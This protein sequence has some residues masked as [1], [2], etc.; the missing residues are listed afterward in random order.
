MKF[1]KAEKQA[2][3]FAVIYIRKI[4]FIDEQKVSIDEEYDR[5]DFDAD[6]FLIE[7]NNNYI[8]TCRIYYKD[9]EATIG[10]V[11]VIKE[12]RNKGYAKF[13]MEKAID[14]I[15]MKKVHTIHIGAQV[16]A[17]GFYEKLGFT[18][19]GDLYLDANIEHY[20]MEMIL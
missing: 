7:E 5:L 13:M 18:V 9:E 16:Q 11:A 14:F 17:L 15:K 10:R 4:V 19:S 6:H 20:P 3:I 8:G 2:E 12:H 1:I